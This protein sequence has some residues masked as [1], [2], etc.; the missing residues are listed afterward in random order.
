MLKKI[1]G[2][3]KIL[4]DVILVAA[5]LVIALSVFLVISLTQKEG[6]YAVVT[7]NGEEVARYSLAL[8]GEYAIGDTNVLVIKGGE[9]YMTYADCPDGLCI[10]QGKISMTGQR[11]VCLPNKVMVEIIGS[12]EEILG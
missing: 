10:G 1:L 9:A 11:I 7:V 8:D 3:K 2:N 6:A 12:E 5:L 4:A